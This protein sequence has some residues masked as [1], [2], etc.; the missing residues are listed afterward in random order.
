MK[1]SALIIPEFLF[2]FRRF[3]SPTILKRMLQFGLREFQRDLEGYKYWLKNMLM[4]LETVSTNSWSFR[5]V[6]AELCVMVVQFYGK[7]SC[8]RKLWLPAYF[9]GIFRILCIKIHRNYTAIHH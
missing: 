7:C 4:N 3:M 6:Q 9:L 2:A 1:F 8:T 5:K